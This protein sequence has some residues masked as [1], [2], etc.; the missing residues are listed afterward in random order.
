MG[1]TGDARANFRLDH[2]AS[3]RIKYRLMRSDK[4]ALGKP[5]N[6]VS[7]ACNGLLSKGI[8]SAPE[9]GVVAFTVPGM[10]DFISREAD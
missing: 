1:D 9:R 8:I 4:E 2:A 10:A 6:A 3:V 7:V 5:R